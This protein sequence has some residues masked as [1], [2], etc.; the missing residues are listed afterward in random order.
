M[1]AGRPHVG[2]RVE[3]LARQTCPRDAAA[4]GCS[5]MELNTSPRLRPSSSSMIA[6][7]SSSSK[8]GTSSCNSRP[9]ATETPTRSDTDQNPGAH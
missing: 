3:C 6:N 1:M 4:M 2:D 9:G 8:D 7:A 5:E